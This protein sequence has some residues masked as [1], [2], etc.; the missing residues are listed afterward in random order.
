[1]L[2]LI[3]FKPVMV[4]VFYMGVAALAN[5]TLPGVSNPGTAVT[6]P[7]FS[8]PGT[9]FA[10]AMLI[11]LAAFCPTL[12]MSLIP[13]GEMA[14]RNAIAGVAA[15]RAAN[16]VEST[17]HNHY[18]LASQAVGNTAGAAARH[19]TR[20]VRS[21]LAPVGRA[22]GA[23]GGYGRDVAAYQA[24][25]ALNAA[26]TTAPG[27]KVSEGASAVKDRVTGA[28]QTVRDQAEALRGRAPNALDQRPPNYSTRR[29]S[30]SEGETVR[31]PGSAGESQRAWA[32][33]VPA[34]DRWT[35]AG[36]ITQEARK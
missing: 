20:G 1:M 7:S 23:T 15:R 18:R 13:L 5:G 6:S 32:R 2:A 35:D 34:P 10:G 14:A 12:L 26:L 16:R 27:Q 22:A 28:A 9:L 36:R 30:T 33:S 17:A 29:P 8:D 31:S 3:L 4:G 19:G 21:M 25:R 11:C 24:G